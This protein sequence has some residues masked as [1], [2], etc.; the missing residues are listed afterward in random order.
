MFK[1]ASLFIGAS[2]TV[3][4]F[5]IFAISNV[6]S[7][8]GIPHKMSSIQKNLIHIKSP[9]LCWMCPSAPMVCSEPG[10][11]K[12]VLSLSLDLI[13]NKPALV[14]IMTWH[15]IGQAIIWITADP[16]HWRIYTAL[17]GDETTHPQY[18]NHRSLSNST[19]RLTP[20]RIYG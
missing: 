2:F 8:V 6:E 10:G 13:D 19:I 9:S 4:V 7:I 1:T 17:G 20:S 16:I 14:Q 12:P 11:Q 3:A 15:R 5:T 18:Y